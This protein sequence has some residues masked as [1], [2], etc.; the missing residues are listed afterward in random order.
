MTPLNP[1]IK[2]MSVIA[3][4]LLIQI[5]AEMTEIIQKTGFAT[6]DAHLHIE[7]SEL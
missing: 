6:A 3:D 1:L 2:E 7:L 5:L 4:K